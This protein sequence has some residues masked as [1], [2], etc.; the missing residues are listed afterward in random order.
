MESIKMNIHDISKLMALENFKYR[1][2]TAEGD[3]LY[4][5]IYDESKIEI[6]LVVEH[7]TFLTDDVTRFGLDAKFSVLKHHL[8]QMYYTSDNNENFVI[9]ATK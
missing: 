5:A 4:S 6:F 2:N 8:K 1:R 7:D 9:E 3:N